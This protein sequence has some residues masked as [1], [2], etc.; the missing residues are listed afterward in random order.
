MILK[1]YDTIMAMTIASNSDERIHSLV[2]VLPLLP[3][4]SRHLALCAGTAN[5][6]TDTLSYALLYYLLSL[7]QHDC[8]KQR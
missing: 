1:L 6:F 7:S 8:Q 5:R 2:G 4:L 3:V